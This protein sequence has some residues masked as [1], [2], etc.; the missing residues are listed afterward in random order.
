[1]KRKRILKICCIVGLL[2]LAIFLIAENE[3][4]RFAFTP[5]DWRLS[6]GDL[7]ILSDTNGNAF[8]TMRESHIG[9]VAI[10]H[11]GPQKQIAEPSGAANRSQPVRPETN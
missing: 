1:M 2:S 9:P 3:R 5:K 10:W 7:M 4:T 11:Y 8:G 6:W